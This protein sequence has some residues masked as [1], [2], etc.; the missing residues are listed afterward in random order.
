MQPLR[1]RVFIPGRGWESPCDADDE[2]TASG[3]PR[4][5]KVRY[6]RFE[7][8]IHAH[9]LSRKT[10]VQA[11]TLARFGD[12]HANVDAEG[13][14]PPPPP[15]CGVGALMVACR[16]LSSCSGYF[17]ASDPGQQSLVG[18]RPLTLKEL[19]A[20]YAAGAIFLICRVLETNT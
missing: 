4:M 20:T 3:V 18:D 14:P 9:R 2:G 10:E 1:L 8:A 5:S 15:N 16:E 13:S 6:D 7:R 19:S 11:P 17:P 12:I